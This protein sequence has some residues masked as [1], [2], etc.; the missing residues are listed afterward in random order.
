M[1]SGYI[2]VASGSMIA[3]LEHPPLLKALAGLSLLTLP[4]QPPPA[5]VPIGAFFSDFGQAFLFD[6]ASPPDAI[7]AR[8]PVPVPRPVRRAP[9]PGVLRGA[10]E[11]R[12]RPGALRRSRSSRSTR[13]WSRTRAWCTRISARRSASWRPC[14]VGRVAAASDRA[15]ARP[16]AARVVLAGVCLGACARVQ[17]L[18]RLP[19]AHSPPPDAPGRAPRGAAGRGA[20]A[21]AAAARS[22]AGAVAAVVLFGVY[23]FATRSIDRR[24]REVGRLGDDRDEGLRRAWAARSRA[25]RLLA[26]TGGLRRR[27]RV[28]GTAERGRRRRQ[29]PVRPA[30]DGGLPVLLLRRLRA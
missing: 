25:R 18:D 27:A 8:A 22:A 1:L 26:G 9:P 12:D 19:G 13:T 3:N 11:V 4:L 15:L 7:A 6:N 29:L 28:R 16:T 21:R 30:L 10:E 14:C 2:A 5:H 20:V 23:A 17:V 24:R